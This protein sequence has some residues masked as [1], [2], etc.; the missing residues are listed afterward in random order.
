MLEYDPWSWHVNC[1]LSSQ[2]QLIG[3]AISSA[4]GRGMRGS[5]THFSLNFPTRHNLAIYGLGKDDAEGFDLPVTSR[6]QDLS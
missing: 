6:V 1:L 4:G 3:K 5:L 2:L